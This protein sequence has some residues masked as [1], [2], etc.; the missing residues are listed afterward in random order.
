MKLYVIFFLSLFIASCSIQD[1]EKTYQY[2][3]VQCVDE[4]WVSWYKTS[5]I[6]FIQE[7]QEKELIVMYYS[8]QE[9]EVILIE[10]VIPDTS[11]CEACNV[12]SKGYFY[13]I[14]VE[15]SSEILEEDGWKLYE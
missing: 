12:C 2:I 14:E 15:G 1:T 13:F 7:P 11:V 3:G 10:K 5:G 8:E 6:N 9:V 4:P